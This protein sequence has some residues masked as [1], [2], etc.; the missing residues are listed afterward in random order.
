MLPY[1]YLDAE[2][3][4]EKNRWGTG[5][6]TQEFFYVEDAADAILMATEGYNK[7]DPV[8]IGAGFEISIKDLVELTGYKEKSF[9][10]KQSPMANHGGCLTRGK[11]LKKLVL[12]QKLVFE[13]V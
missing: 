5:Q 2:V 13:K 8:N 12:K 7:S 9:G 10:M 4:D 3:N 1:S 6:A 11:P